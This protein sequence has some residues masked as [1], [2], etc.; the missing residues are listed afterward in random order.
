MNYRVFATAAVAFVIGA[1][2]GVVWSTQKPSTVSA[3]PAATA[4]AS[5][6]RSAC[7]QPSIER[8]DI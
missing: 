2:S 4:E 3:Q 5:S 8:R 6:K 7:R 1:I